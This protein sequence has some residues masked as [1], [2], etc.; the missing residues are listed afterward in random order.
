MKII[1]HNLKN[2]ILQTPNLKNVIC[3]SVNLQIFLQKLFLAFECIPTFC[4][5]I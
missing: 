2:F 1:G 3:I 5:A 4:D